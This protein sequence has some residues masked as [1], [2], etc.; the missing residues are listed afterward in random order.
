[1]VGDNRGRT[2]HLKK[3]FPV[4]CATFMSVAGAPAKN[5]RSSFLVQNM[6]F[7]NVRIVTMVYDKVCTFSKVMTCWLPDT[8]NVVVTPAIVYETDASGEIADETLK[9]DGRFVPIVFKFAT[10][11]DAPLIFTGLRK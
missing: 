7:A 8:P 5:V 1:M 3:R 10:K 2:F 6:L 11:E 4:S 9:I